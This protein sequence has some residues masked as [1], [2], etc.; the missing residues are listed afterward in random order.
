MNSFSSEGDSYDFNFDITPSTQ[1]DQP[2]AE[3]LY[4]LLVAQSENPDSRLRAGTITASIQSVDTSDRVVD[5]A[6][7]A[8]NDD[9]EEEESVEETPAF[10]I[11]VSV[12]AA[13]VGVALIAFIAIRCSRK[14][15]NKVT[16]SF[17]RSNRADLEIGATTIIPAA[18]PQEKTWTFDRNNAAAASN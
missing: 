5:E 9:S 10:I 16:S 7:F 18:A 6:Y 13:V 3:A 2:T 1:D 17:D 12:A 15:H 14:S 8:H 11:G 4:E